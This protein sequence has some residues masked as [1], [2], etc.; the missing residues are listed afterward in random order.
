M[1]INNIQNV[2]RKPIIY[3]TNLINIISPATFSRKFTDVSYKYMDL[4][5]LGLIVLLHYCYFALH[6]H[7][8]SHH[9][10]FSLFNNEVYIEFEIRHHDHKGWI[11]EWIKVSNH[12]LTFFAWV[13]SDI[14]LTR[15]FILVVYSSTI[16]LA[17]IHWMLFLN[18]LITLKE[19]NT[20]CKGLLP[21][22]RHTQT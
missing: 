18:I 2:P 10:C 9:S 5:N 22:E 6:Y 15:I 11:N 7:Y 21:R 16:Y 1:P 3:P 19:H 4:I 12:F 17:N 20:H 8:V 14:Y 13:K